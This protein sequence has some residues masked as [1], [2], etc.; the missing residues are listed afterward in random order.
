MANICIKSFQV[1]NPEDCRKEFNEVV[2]STWTTYINGAGR[3]GTRLY[4]H[5]FG[6]SGAYSFIFHPVGKNKAFCGCRLYPSH[7]NQTGDDYGAVLQLVTKSRINS[8]YERSTKYLFLFFNKKKFRLPDGT[9]LA[10]EEGKSYY[11]ELGYDG[12]YGEVRIDG[13]VVYRGQYPDKT[14][15]FFKGFSH[16]GYNSHYSFIAMQDFYLNDGDGNVNNSFWGDTKIDAFPLTGTAGG[17]GFASSNDTPLHENVQIPAS[18]EQYIQC[19]KVGDNVSFSV[20][21]LPSDREPLAVAVTAEA[22]KEAQGSYAVTPFIVNS[23]GTV[24]KGE[25]DIQDSEKPIHVSSSFNRAP[26]G[27]EWSLNL[28]NSLTV[29]F[30]IQD[31]N[32]G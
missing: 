12:I 29:G 23:G 25:T 32:D 14:V 18:K 2:S 9:E 1:L 10:V 16:S 11:V 17:S 20:A 4:K 7:T 24:V 3:D 22:Y 31:K 5:S 26:D 28:V 21:N 13:E 6:A 15:Y 19:K 30:E 27:E 8:D